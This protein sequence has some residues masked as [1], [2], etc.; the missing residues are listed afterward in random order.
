MCLPPISI[1]QSLM[2][3]TLFLALI[4]RL[5]IQKCSKCPSNIFRCDSDLH[6]VRWNLH[7][8]L[9]SGSLDS[10]GTRAASVSVVVG[11]QF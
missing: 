9:E 6:L 3:P 11:K 1:V 5:N 2:S 4:I 7:A 10:Q 8:T